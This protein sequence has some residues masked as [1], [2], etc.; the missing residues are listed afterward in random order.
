MWK[1]RSFTANS[2]EKTFWAYLKAFSKWDLLISGR[3]C[4]KVKCQKNNP[5]QAPTT[6]REPD[7]KAADS[8]K[9]VKLQPL[10]FLRQWK[11]SWIQK[12]GILPY[13][14]NFH[15]QIVNFLK[16][17]VSGVK[18]P[19]YK[20]SVRPISEYITESDFPGSISNPRSSKTVNHIKNC[21]QC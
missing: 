18:N 3:L 20:S 19:N 16:I 2:A 14:I 8:Y 21:L 4:I 10:I 1:S 6:F 12:N 13:Q 5:P 11:I 17:I 9:S 15:K 7:I